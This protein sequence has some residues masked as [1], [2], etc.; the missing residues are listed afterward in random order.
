[1]RVLWAGIRTGSART[2]RAAYFPES[3]YG[4]LKAIGDPSA[5]YTYRLLAMF[6]ADLAAYHA[7][8]GARPAASRL[9]DVEA[10]PALVQ[11]IPPGVCENSIGY[12]HLPG[13]RL[14]YATGRYRY[15]VGVFSLISWRGVWYV[16]HLG[17]IARPIGVGTLDDPEVGPGGAGPGGGC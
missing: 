5:D 3:A 6:D 10:D 7:H 17:P 9:V 2:A 13:V 11:W 1:M 16:I 12:W 15:S 14:V 4:Q 8:L